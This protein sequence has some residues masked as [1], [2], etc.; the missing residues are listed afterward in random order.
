[1]SPAH[2][3][4]FP[5]SPVSSN[6]LRLSQP[7]TPDCGPPA[8]VHNVLLAS[9]ANTRWWVGK[10]V[11][12]S[13]ILPLLGSYMERWRVDCSIGV[14]FAEGWSEPLRQ[15][16]GWANWPTREVNQTRPG[17]SLIG[18]CIV[19]WLSQITS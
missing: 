12:I 9:S 16:S 3:C 1:M 11:R 15:K 5:S 8:L 6:T 13:V 10:Q 18:L 2:P 4:D 17:S 7:T 19:A 14:S